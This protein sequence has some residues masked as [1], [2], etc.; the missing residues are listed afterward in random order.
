MERYAET[1]KV[2]KMMLACTGQ[3][4]EIEKVMEAYVAFPNEE[5]AQELSN[6]VDNLET[7]IQNLKLNLAMVV[8]QANGVNDEIV[9]AQTENGILLK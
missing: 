7:S 5:N 1:D 8:K 2:R 3:M 9:V 4:L 6:Q